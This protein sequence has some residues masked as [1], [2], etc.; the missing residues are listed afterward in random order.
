MSAGSNT[1]G[2]G[3]NAIINAGTINIAGVSSFSAA[4]TGSLTFS[5]S[6]G[7]AVNI[8]ANSSATI[9][10][11]VTGS[12]TFSIGNRS[13]LEFGS[14]VALGHTVSFAGGNGL[15][16]LDS[17]STF[18]ATIAGFAVGDIINLLGA[19]VTGTINGSTLTIAEVGGP[20]LITTQVTGA[21]K[22]QHAD[23]ERNHAGSDI[24][25]IPGQFHDYRQ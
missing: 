2:T 14:S 9:N 19:A 6:S 7:S 13:Q 8:A 17:P 3:A 20:T 23:R 24:S 22:V 16:T 12:G 1:F 25:H 4:G 10:G 11:A 18:S 21:V 5:N 15:L